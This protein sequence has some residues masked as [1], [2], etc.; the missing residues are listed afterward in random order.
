M[1]ASRFRAIRDTHHA[2]GA[3]FPAL[4]R[5]VEALPGVRALVKPHPAEPARA[6]TTPCCRERRAARRACS[7][8]G[9]DLLDLLHAADALVTVESLSAVEALVL[10]RPGA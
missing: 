8:R 7:R 2:I 9:A 1:V 5:A 10:G 4:V 3:A 6:P